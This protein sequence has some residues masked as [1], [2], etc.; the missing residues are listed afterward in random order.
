M[1]D[2]IEWLEANKITYEV[3]DGETIDIEGLGKVFYQ[4]M[5]KLKSVFRLD[6]DGNTVFNCA[7]DEKILVAEG[8]CNVAFRFGSY[9]YVQDLRKPFEPRILKHFGKRKPCVHNTR[10]VNLGCHTGF[11]LLNGSFLTSQWVAKAVH[12]G[13][14]AIGVCDANTMGALFSLQQDC[15]AAGI[16]PVFGYSLSCR[17]GSDTVGMKVYVG[18]QEGLGNLL[19][20]QKAVAVDSEDGTIPVRELTARG[21]GNTLVFGKLSA[22]WIKSHPDIVDMLADAFDMVFYQVDLSEYKADRIDSRVLDEANIYFHNEHLQKRTPPVLLC[23]AYYIDMDDSRNKIILNKVA[24]GAAHDQSDDQY[25]KDADE[26][27][28]AFDRIFDREVRD[29]DALFE[30]CCANTVRIADAAVARFD[31]KRNFMPEYELTDDEKARYGTARNMFRR[32]IEDGLERL[33][34][35]DRID[36]YRKRMEYERYIIESTDNVAYYLIQYD[37]VN[38]CREQ[39]IYVGCGRGSAVGSLL[40]YLMGITMVDPLRFELIFERFLTPERAGYL[41]SRA[42]VIAA[43]VESKSWVEI[44]DAAGH[45]VCFDKDAK[46]LVRR[47]GQEGPLE[48]YADEVMAGDE[49]LFDGRDEN[50]TI[51]E[52]WN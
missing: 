50:F 51:K 49:I 8:I 18:S 38:W 31:T 48:V 20:I 13:H 2:L 3:L 37:T 42:S 19:R 36:E 40:L 7:E 24:T 26:H 5:D 16:R 25:F 28:A 11:E 15:G 10:F 32:L 39:G 33:A 46:M 29:V 6:A 12:L 14:D 9:W 23:D 1:K 21:K 35:K 52:L 30:E 4:D 27:Y 47:D 34:P 41:P 44:E 17:V 22:S 45:T 43:D